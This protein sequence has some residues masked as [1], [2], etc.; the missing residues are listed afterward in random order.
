[1][2]YSSLVIIRIGIYGD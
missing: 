1:V 2:S